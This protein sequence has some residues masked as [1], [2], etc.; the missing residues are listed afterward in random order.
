MVQY[1]ANNPQNYYQHPGNKDNNPFPCHYPD[2][3]VCCAFNHNDPG[4]PNNRIYTTSGNVL[5]AS[6]RQQLL[7]TAITKAKTQAGLSTTGTRL[8]S[9]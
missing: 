9:T 2:F 7:P 5:C 3:T 1:P 8:L 6:I 4:N